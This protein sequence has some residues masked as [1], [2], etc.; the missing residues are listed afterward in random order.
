[1]RS[2][3]LGLDRSVRPEHGA[4]LGTHAE[5]DGSKVDA[6]PPKNLD[7]LGL[8][9]DSAATAVEV[10]GRAFKNVDVPTDPAQE[11]PREEPA[12]R[13]ANDQGPPAL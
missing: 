10:M 11:G 5:V 1:M 4:V 8:K 2:E 6:Y 13:P 9:H 7:D 3:V 12:E